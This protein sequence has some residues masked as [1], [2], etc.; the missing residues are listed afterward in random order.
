MPLIEVEDTE[1]A[2]LKQIAEESAPYRQ[3]WGKV[4]GGKR[5]LDALRLVREEF[6]DAPLPELDT[7][8]AASKPILDQIEA[9]RKEHQEYREGVEKREQ[10]RAERERE[11]SAKSTIAASRRKLKSDGWDDEGVEKIETLMQ[12]R[13]IGDYDVAA[14]YVRSQ[15]PTPSPLINGYEGKDLN[16]FNPGEDEPDG[17]LLMENPQRFKGDMIKRFFQDKQAGNLAAWSA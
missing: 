6:P 1:F 4:L 11:T 16:W 12:E 13:G 14:A 7:A 8:E 3:V 17:K 5:K 15:I 9:M 2:R 10:E